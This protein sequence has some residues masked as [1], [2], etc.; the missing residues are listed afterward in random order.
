VGPTVEQV[1]N[2][3]TILGARAIGME[4]EIGSIKVG[5]KADLVVFD[6]SSPAMLAVAARAPLAAIVLHSSVRDIDTVVVDGVI[7]KENGVLK[8]VSI[9]KGIRGSSGDDDEHVT[10]KR[11]VREVTQSSK[12][13]EGRQDPAGD[14]EIARKGIMNGFHMNQAGVLIDSLQ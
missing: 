14:P 2:L 13:I 1:Y 5:K 10:W 3:G 12:E 7:R 6:G 11:I 9:P 4:N 8:E